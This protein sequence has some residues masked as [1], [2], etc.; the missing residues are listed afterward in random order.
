MFGKLALL[1]GV[2]YPRLNG[3]MLKFYVQMLRFME[4]TFF[5]AETFYPKQEDAADKKD[6]KEENK[7]IEE[8]NIVL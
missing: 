2:N 5:M 8:S 3:P 6:K 7:E 4:Q 1:V